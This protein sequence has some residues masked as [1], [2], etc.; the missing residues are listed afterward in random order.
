LGEDEER[1]IAGEREQRHGF[2]KITGFLAIATV[3]AAAPAL[4]AVFLSETK[5]AEY[6]E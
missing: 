3:T 6:G 5:P 4:L 1:V 2:G